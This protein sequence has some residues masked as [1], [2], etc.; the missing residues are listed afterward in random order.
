MIDK[1][2]KLHVFGSDT[3]A[4]QKAMLALLGQPIIG[5]SS[6]VVNHIAP[7]CDGLSS[8]SRDTLDQVC[9]II[10]WRGSRTIV[11]PTGGLRVV[12]PAND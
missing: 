9:P 2:G 3:T 7:L 4:D 8:S 11:T 5:W 6:T 1:S 12:P 10:L